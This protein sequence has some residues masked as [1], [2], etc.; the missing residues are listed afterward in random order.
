MKKSRFKKDF[1][2]LAAPSGGGKTTLCNL[3]LKRYPDTRLSVSYTTR[4]PR[5]NEQDGVAY[6]FVSEKEFKKLIESDGL[7]E[8]A[9]VHGS[10]YGTS[11]D[12]ITKQAADG[13]VVL[14][15]IDIQGVDSLKKLYPDRTLSVFLL[16]P[17]FADL[18]ARLRARNTESEE[19][20]QARLAAAKLELEH[21]VRFD[22]QLMNVDLDKTF[23]ELCEI[24][25]RDVGLV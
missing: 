12:F 20:I 25:E 2:A 24:L 4:P 5:G 1:I 13:K 15:D 17:S 23:A 19:K 11:K 9:Q 7:V 3:I 16:P 6:H 18:E 8:W 21:S 14:L 22:H 10:Y